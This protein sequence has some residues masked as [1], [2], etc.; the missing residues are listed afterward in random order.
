MDDSDVLKCV[1][2]G[3]RAVGLGRPV[4]YAQSVRLFVLSPYPCSPPL[5]RRMARQAYS[6]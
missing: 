4:L 3:A 6:A 2:L 1:C 5:C